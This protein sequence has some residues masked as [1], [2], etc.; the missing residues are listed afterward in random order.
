MAEG[1]STLGA[2][3]VIAGLTRNPVTFDFVKDT[4]CRIKSGMT[5]LQINTKS[6]P[7]VAGCVLAPMIAM[8]T[9]AAPP[10]PSAS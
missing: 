1:E 7:N 9:G 8:V 2:P 6:F 4:G 5:L 3:P 10:V